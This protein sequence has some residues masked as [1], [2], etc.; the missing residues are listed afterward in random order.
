LAIG[1]EGLDRLLAQPLGPRESLL[2]S[3]RVYRGGGST[4]EAVDLLQRRPSH[5]PIP[6]DGRLERRQ[7]HV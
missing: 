4:A 3:A 7:Q 2:G 6:R 5:S 1:A